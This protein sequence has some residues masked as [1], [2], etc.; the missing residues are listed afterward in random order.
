MGHE[1]MAVA[2]LREVFIDGL[3]MR[4]YVKRQLQ[5]RFI[6]LEVNKKSGA[7]SI[8]RKSPIAFFL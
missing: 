3:Q 8:V 1:S 4:H 2:P 5:K 7:K 6:A